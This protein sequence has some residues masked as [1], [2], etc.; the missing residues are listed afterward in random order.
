MPGKI[1]IIATPDGFA[2]KEIL[3]AWV[4]IELTLTE[5]D[6]K[7]FRLDNKG[8]SDH[9]VELGCAVKAL[10]DAGKNNAAEY[11]SQFVPG[12]LIFKKEVCQLL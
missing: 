12:N 7:G 2:P 1:R 11:W 3:E 9:E 4:G 10:I 5:Q 8:G 6:F